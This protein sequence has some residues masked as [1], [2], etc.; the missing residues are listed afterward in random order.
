MRQVNCPGVML[1]A[2]SAVMRYQYYWGASRGFLSRNA[3]NTLGREL[4]RLPDVC[5]LV[6]ETM[7]VVV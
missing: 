5:Q 3:T 7:G 4:S 6:R 1:Y 2:V